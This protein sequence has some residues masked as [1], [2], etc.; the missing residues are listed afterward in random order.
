MGI[1]SEEP[2]MHE[3]FDLSVCTN[4]VSPSHTTA[5]SNNDV[6]G[7]RKRR[8]SPQAGHALEMLGHA[9]EYLTDELVHEGGS[10]SAHNG[11]IEAIQLLMAHNR[12]VYFS[13]PEIP[14]FGDQCRA[15][16]RAHFHWPIFAGSGT[17]KR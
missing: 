1:S 16:L 9:I 8:I 3:S 4:V 14:G 11:Q 2:N 15:F 7:N 17:S 12:A 13:C 5:I 10:L 6:R